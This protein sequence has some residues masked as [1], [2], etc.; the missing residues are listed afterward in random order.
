M[1]DEI[2]PLHRIIDMRL[3]AIWPI[4]A[5]VHLLGNFTGHYEGLYA[6]TQGALYAQGV[7]IVVLFAAMMVLVPAV[8]RH[9]EEEFDDGH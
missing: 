7:M 5:T 3:L 2:T 8:Q 6:Q 4:V 9:A 1:S